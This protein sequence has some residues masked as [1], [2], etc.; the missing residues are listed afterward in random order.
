MQKEKNCSGTD[1]AEYLGTRHS[2]TVTW[3]QESG[4]VMFSSKLRLTRLPS[5]NVLPLVPSV[6]TSKALAAMPRTR[7]L[8]QWPRQA[9]DKQDIPELKQSRRVIKKSVADWPPPWSPP[10]ALLLIRNKGTVMTQQLIKN[11]PL[12]SLTNT[13]LCINVAFVVS[14]YFRNLDMRTFVKDDISGEDIENKLN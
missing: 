7:V 10:S 4:T 14:V 3:K 8:I 9:R 1:E 11:E 6:H 12:L 5:R 2:V 13:W